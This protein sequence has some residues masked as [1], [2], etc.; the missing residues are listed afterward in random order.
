MEKKN[1]KWKVEKEKAIKFGNKIKELR[2]RKSIS[3][4][5][6]ADRT[7]IDRAD[8]SRIESAKKDYINPLQVTA[9]AQYF[10]INP[11]HFL[12][13]LF[14]PEASAETLKDLS[15]KKMNGVSGLKEESNVYE[16]ENNI[17]KYVTLPVYGMASAG[18]G[19]L[20]YDVVMEEFILP[21][22]FEVPKDSFI[23]GVYGESME[24]I[25]Y[26]GDRIMVDTSK[27]GTEWQFLVDYPV[28][29]QINEERFVKVVK[30]NNY[31][32]EFHSLNQMYAP[33]TVTNGDEIILVGVVTEI[34]KRKIGKIKL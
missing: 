25:F 29:V 4:G 6:L 27:R 21:A 16:V 3:M 17:P 18:T 32:P 34:L 33:I 20:D 14:I 15:F 24:P 7:G 31:K 22:D 28:V 12:N 13:M 19:A 23:I 8:I 2:T 9:L 1:D 30:F 10:N 11:S 5:Q 26:D